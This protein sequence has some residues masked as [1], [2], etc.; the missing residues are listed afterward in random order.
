[1][2]HVASHRAP[3]GSVARLAQRVRR[4]GLA[5]SARTAL[6]RVAHLAYLHEE[7]VWYRLDLGSAWPRL[8]LPPGLTLRRPG[9]GE[10]DELAARGAPLDPVEAHR[11]LGQG[12]V[13]WTVQNDD[14]PVFLCWTFTERVPL[15]A[16]PGGAMDLPAGVVCQKDSWTAPAHRG[17]RIGPAAWCAIAD[18][19]AASGATRLIGKTTVGNTASRRAHARAGYVE[20]TRMA[21]VR[22]GPWRRVRVTQ[23]ASGAVDPLTELV[24]HGVLRRRGPTP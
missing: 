16:A 10:L 11:L 14:G 20:T 3:S 4:K 9:P 19:Y 1:M 12:A 6:E 24:R 21:L 17:A 18:L 8:E 22:I 13:L 5:A 15:F 2:T 7:H 23:L